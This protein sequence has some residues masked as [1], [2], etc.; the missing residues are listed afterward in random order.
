MQP[1]IG[2][3]QPGFQGKKKK[4]EQEEQK[5]KKQE[6][7][8]KE[9]LDAVFTLLGRPRDLVSGRAKNVFDNRWRVS[10]C[11]GS[12]PNYNDCFFLHLSEDGE[13]E[14]SDPPIER[15]YL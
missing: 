7:R 13:I 11:S 2:Q 10:I 14:K 4:R 12:P 8:E 1:N 5:Q 9:V 6:V 3:H 15:K